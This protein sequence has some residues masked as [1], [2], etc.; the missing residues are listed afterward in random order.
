M[1]VV[2][3]K[4]VNGDVICEVVEEVRKQVVEQQKVAGNHV[5]SLLLLLLAPLCAFR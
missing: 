3:G 2:G 1:A 4:V 5:V